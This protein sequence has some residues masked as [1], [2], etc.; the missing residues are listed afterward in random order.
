MLAFLQPSQYQLVLELT[1][2]RFLFL[3]SA[4]DVQSMPSFRQGTMTDIFV[5]MTVIQFLSTP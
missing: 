3:L 2:Y 1:P 4:Y 5:F